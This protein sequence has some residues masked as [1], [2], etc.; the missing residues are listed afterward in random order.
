MK[1]AESAG[2]PPM[3]GVQGLAIESAGIY[4]QLTTLQRCVVDTYADQTTL[5]DPAVPTLNSKAFDAA[6]KQL[7]E[8][9]L[10]DDNISKFLSWIANTENK[11]YVPVVV[12]CVNRLSSRGL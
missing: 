7:R 9:I 11:N 4:K 8:D 5:Y 1:Y 6:A 10:N 2:F 3:P 12:S